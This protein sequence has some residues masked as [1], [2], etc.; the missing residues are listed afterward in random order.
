MSKPVIMFIFNFVCVKLFFE[1]DVSEVTKALQC[2]VTFYPS[3]LVFKDAQTR[4]MIGGCH[5]VNG[6]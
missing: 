2:S 6:L 3:F 4:K 5:K 1:P